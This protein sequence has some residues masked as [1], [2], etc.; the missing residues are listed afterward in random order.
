MRIRC[1]TPRTNLH[2]YRSMAYLIGMPPGAKFRP[3]GRIYQAMLCR[4]YR[5]RFWLL[6]HFTL[7]FGDAFFLV[8]MTG[9]I[10][11]LSIGQ[12]LIPIR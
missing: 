6:D 4:G 8:L 10:L 3:F 9:L 5:G 11:A 1:F 12:W 7:R 2:T